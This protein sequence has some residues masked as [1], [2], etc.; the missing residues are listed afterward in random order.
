VTKKVTSPKAIKLLRINKQKY[1]QAIWQCGAIFVMAVFLGF[2]TNQFR[3]NR[4]PLFGNWTIESRLVTPSDTQFGISLAEAKELFLKQGAVFIDARPNNDYEKGHIKGAHSLPWHD[5]DQQSIE[6]TKD[7]PPD[8]PI[9]TYCDGETCGL[10]HDLTMFLL[11]MGFNNVRVLINGW[12]L[13]QKADLPVESG[14]S[15]ASQG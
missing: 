11:D 12:A 10:S 2:S 14:N 5:I 8:I 4:L 1:L 13:W 7:L 9:I 3:N 6:V 15:T